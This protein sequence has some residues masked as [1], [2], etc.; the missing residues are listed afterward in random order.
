MAREQLCAIPYA[1]TRAEAERLR[2]EFVRTWRRTHPK[3]VEIL[4]SA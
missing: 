3:A 4:K 2:D 1:E